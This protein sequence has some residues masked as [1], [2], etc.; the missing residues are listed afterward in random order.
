M[1]TSAAP[2]A[3]TIGY[4]SRCVEG[5]Y[6]GPP[7]ETS[8]GI[9]EVRLRALVLGLVLGREAMSRHR[10]DPARQGPGGVGEHGAPYGTSALSPMVEPS[11]R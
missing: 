11:R 7:A 2:S 6:L 8:R 4:R 9:Y 3:S 1:T 5:A 10:R